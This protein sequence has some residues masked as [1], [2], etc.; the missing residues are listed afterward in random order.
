MITASIWRDLLDGF[1]ELKPDRS[2]EDTLSYTILK[3][4]K[5]TDFFKKELENITS[6][7]ASLKKAVS[8]YRDVKDL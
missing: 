8:C 7:D 3:D 2:S 5:A 4:F 1:A 6:L